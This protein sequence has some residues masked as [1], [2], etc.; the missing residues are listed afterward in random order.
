MHCG[1]AG[2]ALQSSGSTDSL[3]RATD[4]QPN[5]ATDELLPVG[6][7]SKQLLKP[8]T[9]DCPSE[10]AEVELKGELRRNDEK[11]ELEPAR[12]SRTVKIHLAL[13]PPAIRRFVSTT[14]Q[15]MP[16]CLATAS[17]QGVPGAS[18]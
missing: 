9:S 15:A 5:L 11:G 6:H 16:T 3:E 12:D 13:V 7:G 2:E 8:T 4:D 18:S 10:K 1:F 17:M 14:M